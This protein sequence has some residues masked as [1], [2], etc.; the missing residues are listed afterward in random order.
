MYLYLPFYVSLYSH[1][2]SIYIC[3]RFYIYMDNN[4]YGI[5][6]YINKYNIFLF[7]GKSVIMEIG[8]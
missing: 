5:S 2:Y 8:K 1:I 6:L 4:T 7:T 3:L